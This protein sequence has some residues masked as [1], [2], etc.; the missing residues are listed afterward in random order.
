MV[1]LK[2]IQNILSNLDGDYNVIICPTNGDGANDTIIEINITQGAIL[3][4]CE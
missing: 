3:V 1:K 2:E 4:K